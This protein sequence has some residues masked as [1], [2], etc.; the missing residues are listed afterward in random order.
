MPTQYDEKVLQGHVDWLY[1]QARWIIAWTTVRWAV[2]GVAFGLL[3]V[4]VI[5]FVDRSSF[6]NLQES[7]GIGGF[8]C[9]AIGLV[10]GLNKG[11]DLAT[12]LRLEAQKLLCD[13]QIERNTRRS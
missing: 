1:R 12:R 7:S 9:G 4:F 13:M 6:R 5:Q 10:V 3:A 11:F 2:M 8:I